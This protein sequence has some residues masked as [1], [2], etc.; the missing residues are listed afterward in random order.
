MENE[1]EK[2]FEVIDKR[3]RDKE[4]DNKEPEKEEPKAEPKAESKTEAEQ[5]ETGQETA[6]GDVY[7]L[8]QWMILMLTESAWQWMGLRTN[9]VTKKIQQDFTQ[10]KTAIDSIVYL[11][12]QISPHVS[13]EQRNAYRTLISDLRVNFVQKSRAS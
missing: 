8:I 4:P 7:S 12:D 6:T 13:E 3:V 2:G 5:E 10:A 11:V 1:Q 9:T